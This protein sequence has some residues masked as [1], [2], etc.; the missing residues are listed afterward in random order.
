MGKLTVRS[1]VT[2]GKIRHMAAC[3]ADPFSCGAGARGPAGYSCR[4]LGWTSF[5]ELPRRPDGYHGG[6]V[7]GME[8]IT[9]DG[10]RI[11]EA[12]Q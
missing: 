9:R 3:F 2:P 11:L 5:V 12:G 7:L 4:I 1:A 8:C 10:L 6:F